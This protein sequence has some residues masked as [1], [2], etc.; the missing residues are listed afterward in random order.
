M[1]QN[2]APKFSKKPIKII[3]CGLAGAE[4]ALILANNG[5]DVH[6]FDNEENQPNHKFYYYDQFENFMLENMS[7]E[8]DCLNSP[9]F[10]IAKKLGLEN[11]WHEYSKDFMFS[12]RRELELNNKIKIFK[13]DINSL[14]SSETQVIATGHKT[15]KPL[16]DELKNY[17][18]KMHT[19][20]Y[21]PTKMVIDASSVNF[22]ELNFISKFDCFAN[23]S[24]EDYQNLCQKV[25]EFDEK[26]DKSENIFNERQITIEGMVRYSVE[27]LRNSTLRPYFN[28]KSKCYASLKLNFNPYLN[29]LF[30]ENFFSAMDEEEQ[31]KIIKTI[32]ALRNAN[33]LRCSSVN[34]KTYLLAP[35][36]INKN[37][38]IADNIFVCGGFAGTSG[39]FESLL[40]ANLCAYSIICDKIGNSAVELLHENTCIG[41]IIDGLLKKSVINFR[42]FNLKYDIMEEVDLEKFNRETQ[43]QKILSKSQIEKFKEKLYG[44]YF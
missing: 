7:Y 11:F 44:K 28:K 13:A 23:L 37:M 30:V 6:I 15:T 42:L 32:P 35:A 21:N 34:R 16:L 2:I 14:N 43:I 9:L 36:C 22:D 27:S 29:I 18:G 33:V 8:L 24:K 40:M 41:K 17:I 10:F 26:Y 5:F 1:I 4:V 20:F 19:R 38:Q 25:S 12:V 31:T 39:S 3:G